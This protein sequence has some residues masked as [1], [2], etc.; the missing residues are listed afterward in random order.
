MRAA[1]RSRFREQKQLAF[2]FLVC[3]LHRELLDE[4]SPWELSQRT[5]RRL[6]IFDDTPDRMALPVSLLDRAGSNWAI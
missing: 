1:F 6:E 5:P 2:S 3:V 4:N